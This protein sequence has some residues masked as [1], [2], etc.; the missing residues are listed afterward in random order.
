MVIIS[1][2]VYLWKGQSYLTGDIIIPEKNNPMF[3]TWKTENHMVMSW[4]INSMTNEIGEN[5]LLYGTAKEIWEAARETYSSSENTSELFEIEAVLHD[6]RQGELSITQYFNTLCRHWQHLDMFEIHSWNCPKDTI[7]YRRI[8]EQKRTFKFL[9]GL[10]KNLDEVRGR[11]MGTKPLSN[12]R[13]AFSEVRREESRKKVM[14]GPHN[15]AHIMERFALVARG[16]SNSNYDN[17]QRKGRPWCDHCNKPGHVKENCW[18][19]HGKPADWKPSKSV[20]DKDRRANNV[21]SDYN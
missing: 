19:I 10:N 14:M 20:N 17:R 5:F 16:Y 6:L 3:R 18:K 11:I 13:E 9:L 1:H 21:I 4:L 8:V 15:S 12:L 7:L 2:D